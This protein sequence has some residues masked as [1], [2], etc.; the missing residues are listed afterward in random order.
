MSVNKNTGQMAWDDPRLRVAS[1]TPL[2]AERR[3][4]QSW[5][6]EVRLGARHA[7]RGPAGRSAPV[8]SLLD[9][10]EVLEDPALNFLGDPLAV[11]YAESRMSAVSAAGG[12]AEADRV[13]RNLLS[14]MPMALSLAAS[15]RTADDPASIV[16]SAF[17]IPCASILDIEAEWMPDDPGLRIGRTAFDIAIR[18]LSHDGS[19]GLLGIET[20]YTE[21][22]SKAYDT[23]GFRAVHRAT[24]CFHP[25]SVDRLARIETNQL[26][27]N[28]LLAGTCVG[29]GTC[30]SATVVALG[31][32]DDADLRSVAAEV[33]D[34]A[35]GSTQLSVSFRSWERVIDSFRHTELGSFGH[36]FN[37]RYLDLSQ[38]GS[39][40]RR[41]AR[42]RSVAGGGRGWGRVPHSSPPR[43]ERRTVADDAMWLGWVPTVWRALSDPVRAIALPVWPPASLEEATAWWTP[44]EH[45]LSYRLGWS[46]PADG[47]RRWEDL[48]RPLEDVALSLIESVWG[49]HLDLI[50]AHFDAHSSQGVHDG[51]PQEPATVDHV[52]EDS[53]S[54]F[55]SPVAHDNSDPL[56]LSTHGGAPMER[57]V[58]RFDLL[59][60]DLGVA[61]P[62]RATVVGRGYEG[63]YAALTQLGGSLPPAS[64][65]GW[66]VDVV[67][68]EIGHLGTFRQSRATGR[69]FAGQHRWHE[70]GS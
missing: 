69:W 66:R 50:V 25:D 67:I 62:P 22:P 60:G 31:L 5:Y 47:L 32:E 58:E 26:W 19:V 17:E 8:G 70:L 43:P 27:R 35:I 21:S 15:L 52:L 11:A 42:R 49:R 16:A 57:S 56:H 13:R 64:R 65:D 51:A 63:W 23:A 1:D 59:V 10:A 53:S 20:K 48:G 37:E 18:Y 30:D 45:L 24:G 55:S 29:S 3:L 14:S 4:L 7:D 54:W 46:R 68:E 34:A 40:P 38:I 41:P 6:R 9:P 12:T 61:G 39:Q 28:G 44:I 2:R 36:C 33:G